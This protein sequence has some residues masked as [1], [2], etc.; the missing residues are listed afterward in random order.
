MQH[1]VLY[2]KK[3]TFYIV[4]EWKL[5][6]TQSS[7]GANVICV[8]VLVHKWFDASVIMFFIPCEKQGVRFKSLYHHG[9][10]TV[11]KAIPEWACVSEVFT[12]CVQSASGESEMTF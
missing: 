12:E 1:E 5:Q 10:F 3:T 2:R 7:A 6:N 9:G 4:V 8:T 11:D